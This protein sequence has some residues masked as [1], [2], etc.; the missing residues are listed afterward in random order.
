LK[1]EDWQYSPV[2][3]DAK[4]KTVS[5]GMDGTCMLLCEDGYRQAMVGTLAFY[6]K[7]GERLH[8]TYLAAPP[9]Y[10]KEKFKKHKFSVIGREKLM[11]AISYFKNNYQEKRMDYADHVAKNHSI[12]SGITEAACK[13]IVKQ[14]L[15]ESGMKWKN[16]GASIELSMRTLVYSGTHSNQF[17]GKIS[18]YG[19]PIAA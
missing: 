10:G 19:F 9:E 14:P 5:I 7:N 1:E 8:T 15:C 16:K 6:D 11:A 12:G 18:Q 17:W 3:V 4:V 2:I 13:V